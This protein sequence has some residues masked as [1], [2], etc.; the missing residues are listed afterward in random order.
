MELNFVFVESKTRLNCV[1]FQ[2]VVAKQCYSDAGD[3]GS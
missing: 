3:L 2:A 1:E